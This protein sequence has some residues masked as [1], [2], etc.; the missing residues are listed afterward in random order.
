MEISRY[1]GLETDNQTNERITA[2]NI[3]MDYE[4]SD[5]SIIFKLCRY[6]IRNSW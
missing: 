5:C 2:L 4:L 1:M 3:Y 6:C